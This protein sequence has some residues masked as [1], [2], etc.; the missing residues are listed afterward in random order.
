MIY[1]DR[2]DNTDTLEIHIE[3]N[4]ATFSDQVKK[5][6]DLA[7]EISADIQSVLGIKAAVL[8]VEPRSIQRS[9]GKAVR[10]IDKRKLYK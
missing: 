2:V 10:V 3:V 6:E 7:R 5:L 9:E 1:V 8:L 4:E